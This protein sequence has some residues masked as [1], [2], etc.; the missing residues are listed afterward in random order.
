MEKIDSAEVDLDKEL[1]SDSEDD[2]SD[3]DS[4][5]E[6][7]DDDKITYTCDKKLCKIPCPCLFCYKDGELQCSEHWVK[8]Q[9]LFDEQSD[10]VVARTTDTFCE[11]ETFFTRSYLSK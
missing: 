10:V 4:E 6:D 8:H 5:D 7:V 2:E 9:D 3:I 1:Y 11:D